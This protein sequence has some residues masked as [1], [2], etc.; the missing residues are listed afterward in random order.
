MQAQSVAC[1]ADENSPFRERYFWRGW[2]ADVGKKNSLPDRRT[3]S[4]LHVMNVEH[5]LRE[6]F[7]K[8]ARLDL[9]RYLRA[10]Q[11]LLQL[12]QRLLGTRRQVDA[13][14]QGQDPGG[15][16]EDGEHAEKM[17]NSDAAGPHGG[18]FAVGGK[19]AQ[20]DEDPDQNPGWQSDGQRLRN[21]ENE[22]FEGARE[23]RAVADNQFENLAEFSGVND[24]RENG[25]ADQRMRRNFAENVASEN[26]H[27]S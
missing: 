21:N 9:K 3:L 17:P 22:K 4:A 6:A 13:V 1:F 26:A 10:L 8:N 18:D 14:A 16:K 2:I 12:R 20:P 19:T 25:G 23:R 24:E 27:G 7:I 5:H 11:L 15:E